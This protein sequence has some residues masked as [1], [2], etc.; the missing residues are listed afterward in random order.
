ML[1]SPL[2]RSPVVCPEQGSRTGCL[3]AYVTERGAVCQGG[4]PMTVTGITFHF[5]ADSIKKTVSSLYDFC[6]EV[7]WVGRRSCFYSYFPN[8]SWEGNL[9]WVTS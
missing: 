2:T 3:L 1:L 6:G 4:L 7:F 5:N 9:N 8:R